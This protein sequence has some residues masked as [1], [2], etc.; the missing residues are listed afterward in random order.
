ML[1]KIS[2]RSF[3]FWYFRKLNCIKFKQK[4]INLNL[5]VYFLDFKKAFD[6]A[7]HKVS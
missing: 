1:T 7:L 5:L 2:E 4:M 3:Y 6:A